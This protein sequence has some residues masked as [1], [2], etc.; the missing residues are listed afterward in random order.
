MWK[1]IILQVLHAILQWLH[2]IH[3]H[4]V[5]IHAE[6]LVAFQDGG[7]GKGK[8]LTVL[9]QRRA[10]NILIEIKR[11]PAVRHIKAAILNMDYSYFSR[12]IVE[13]S[14]GLKSGDPCQVHTHTHVYM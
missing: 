1:L 13:V 11:L 7:G 8:S 14:S 3:E 12:E 9:E 2:S 5:L 6:L 10:N 4:T